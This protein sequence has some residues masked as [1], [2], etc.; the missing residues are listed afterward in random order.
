MNKYELWSLDGELL[1]NGND[2]AIFSTIVGI[3]YPL[4]NFMS[5]CDYGD[6]ITVYFENYNIVVNKGA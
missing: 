5:I 3:N 2:H 1:M 6:Y 4:G